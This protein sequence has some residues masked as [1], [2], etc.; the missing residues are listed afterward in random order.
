MSRRCPKC[1]RLSSSPSPSHSHPS[2]QPQASKQAQ[3][4]DDTSASTLRIRIRMAIQMQQGEPAM[5]REALFTSRMLPGLS[6]P[7][8]LTFL[9]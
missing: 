7:P 2:R 8:A 1:A 5:S 9:D 6:R 4:K 3:P